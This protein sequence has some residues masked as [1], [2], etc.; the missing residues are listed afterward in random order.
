MRMETRRLEAKFLSP[1]FLGNAQQS[2]QWRTPPFKALLRQWWRVATAAQKEFHLAVEQL[3][4]E[5]AELFGSAAGDQGRRSCLRLRLNRW[6]QGTLKQGEWPALGKIGQSSGKGASVD[7]GLYLGYGPVEL[8]KGKS[9]PTLKR[10]AAIQAGESAI[11]QLAFPAEHAE[12]V[13]R[14]LALIHRFGALG[15]RSR[16]GWG[17]LSLGMDLGM[18]ERNPLPLPLRDWHDCLD[19]DWVHA[20]GCDDRGALV[21]QTAVHDDWKSMMVELAQTRKALCSLFPVPPHSN[22]SEP[23]DWLSYPVTKHSV[24]GWGNLRLPNS[25]RFKVVEEPNGQLRAQIF[26]MPCLPNM[27]FHP[28]QREIERVWQQVHAWLDHSGM[29]RIGG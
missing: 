17:S 21:W 29:R 4:Q 6:D 9:S 20:I 26:H 28:D 13:D 5:E 19:R 10:N 8:P 23:R 12:C 22:R 16:N 3:R 25:L 24:R 27:K 1:A 7:A 15:G 11:L 14:A 18:D 2:G